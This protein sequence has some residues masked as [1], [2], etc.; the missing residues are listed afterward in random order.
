MQKA[1]NAS[2]KSTVIHAITVLVNANGPA[3]PSKH[4]A[5]LLK[6]LVQEL[7]DNPSVGALYYSCMCGGFRSRRRRAR[8]W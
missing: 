6:K 3:Y 5:E 8:V 1:M 2:T 7:G 4:P